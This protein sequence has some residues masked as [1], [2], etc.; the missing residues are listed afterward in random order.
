MTYGEKAL[1]LWQIGNKEQAW[2]HFLKALEVN[3]ADRDIIITLIKLLF[4]LG[5][6]EDIVKICN[7][8]L[9][10]CP[11]DRE[12]QTILED[13]NKA[14]QRQKTEKSLHVITAEQL[15]QLYGKRTELFSDETHL[16]GCISWLC[17]AQQAN[18]RGGVAALYDMKAQ[19]WAVRKAKTQ[20]N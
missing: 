9:K 13:A 4:E 7:D 18:G 12:I 6:L 17:N 14:V 19:T 10:I 20:R 3:P 1:N 11:S 8:Y 2:Q 16:R 15:N 5:R